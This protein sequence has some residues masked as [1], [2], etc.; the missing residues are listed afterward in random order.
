MTWLAPLV[1][2]V[3]LLSGALVAGGDHVAP[4]AL[5]NAIGVCGSAATFVLAVLLFRAAERHEVLT[6]FGGWRP[7][8]GIAVGIDFAVDP[9]AAGMCA[10]IAGLSCAALVYSITYMPEA[11]KLYDTLLLVAAGSMCG[12]VLSGDLFNLFVWL[13]LTAVA[14][15][16]LTGFEVKQL[17]PLQG[18]LNFAI[19]NTLGGYF[20]L[21]GIALVYARTGALNLA[22]IG[23]AL[24][25]RRPDGL[26][27][28]AFTLVVCGFLCK[29]AVVPFHFWLADAYA[30]A[31]APVCMVF[32]GVM[33]D[34]GLVGVARVYATAFSGAFGLH[35][36]AV[37][38]LLL[39]LGIVSALVGGVMSLVQRH[40]KRMLAYSV[41][42]HIGIMLAGIGLLSSKALGGVA[43]LLLAHGLATGALFLVA[44]MLLASLRSIDELRLRGRARARP[45]LAALWF[46]GTIALIG[47]PYVGAYLGHAMID[48]AAAEL[49][50]HWVQPLLW[51]AGALSGAA[52]LRAGARI[53]LGFGRATAEFLSPDVR[54]DPP[55]RGAN[56]P[57]LGGTT[58]VLAI[59]GL[60]V[61]VVP[62]LGP[63]VDEGAARFLDRRSYAEH[64]LHGGPFGFKHDL[65]FA[66]E[67]TSLES[68]IYAVVATLLALA[69]A[70]VGLRPPRSLSI[71][72]PALAGLKRLHSGVVGDYVVWLTVGTAV[73]GGVW[74]VTLR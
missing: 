45:W 11:A 23:S 58:A 20:V 63:R 53:F 65:P 50:R 8:S 22:Q 38:D 39:W 14:G 17:G 24:S 49:G 5:Q 64:V 13:E 16:A 6:W 25:T 69:I 26:V 10:L 51:L 57:L 70:A 9:L 71:V 19:V 61:S 3:P 34:I 54:E 32:A 47:P 74:A 18:A 59:A 1:V 56:L 30:V 7:R 73:V 52:L 36:H 27:I 37:G 68:V 33:T 55:D 62:G 40:L 67:H 35:A 21:M 31:P 28:V 4:R 43:A 72:E 41:I 66:I 12:F 42:C 29:A 15:Y 48:D 46:V 60:V 2:A 44:G